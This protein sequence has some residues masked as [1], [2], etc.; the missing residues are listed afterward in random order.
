MP[1]LSASLGATLRV[2]LQDRP[3]AF[4][5]LARAIAETGGSPD[6]VALVRVAG[7]TTV[8]DV[9]VRARDAVHMETPTAAV[10]ALAVE[11]GGVPGRRREAAP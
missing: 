6:A 11:E 2:R 5:E 9:A 10:R 7:R 8:R 1:P 3:G 4:A